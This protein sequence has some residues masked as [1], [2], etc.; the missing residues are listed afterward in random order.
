MHGHI[1]AKIV[2]L[3]E[4]KVKLAKCLALKRKMVIIS[5]IGN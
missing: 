5:I 4:L 2:T 3:E 1:W